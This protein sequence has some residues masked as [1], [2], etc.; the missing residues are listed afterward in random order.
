MTK[1]IEFLRKYKYHQILQGVL[2]YR[3]RKAYVENDLHFSD[4]CV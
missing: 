3:L 4:L 1:S 2:L